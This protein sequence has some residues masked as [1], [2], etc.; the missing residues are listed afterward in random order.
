LLNPANQ[1]DGAH[2]RKSS[3]KTLMK[4]GD[5]MHDPVLIDLVL[6]IIDLFWWLRK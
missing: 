5:I 6:A 2:Q 4:G 1:R 3:L